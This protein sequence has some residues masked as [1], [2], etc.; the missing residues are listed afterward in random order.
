MAQGYDVIRRNCNHFSQAFLKA[1]GINVTIP[2]NI[3]QLAR[4]ISKVLPTARPPNKMDVLEERIMN[5]IRLLHREQIFDNPN[6]QSNSDQT[7]IKFRE[8]QQLKDNI[9]N[10]DMPFENIQQRFEEIHRHI[11]ATHNM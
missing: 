2:T 4:G 6:F 8:L 9:T 7:K 3:N 1:L 5:D 11:H 10:Q